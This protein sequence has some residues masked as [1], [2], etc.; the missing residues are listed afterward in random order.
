ML[1]DQCSRF[2]P[3]DNTA[4]A[5]LNCNSGFPRSSQ[6][7]S[8]SSQVTSPTPVLTLWQPPLTAG[9]VRHTVQHCRRNTLCSCAVN[10]RLRTSLRSTA[11]NTIDCDNIYSGCYH[12]FARTTNL[13]FSRIWKSDVCKRGNLS[14]VIKM[15]VVEPATAIA[16][17]SALKYV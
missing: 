1:I 12:C 2:F 10:T 6:T 7:T 4:A 14:I 5:P 8:I 3:A 9:T 16:I 11:R 13:V 15:T 17:S